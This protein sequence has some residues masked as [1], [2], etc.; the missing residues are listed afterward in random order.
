MIYH[1][2]KAAIPCEF[3]DVRQFSTSVFIPHENE[4]LKYCDCN[5]KNFGRKSV[6]D[7]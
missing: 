6:L 5:H 4:D 2:I 1:P 7:R 3:R